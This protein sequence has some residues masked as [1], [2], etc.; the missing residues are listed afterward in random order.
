MNEANRVDD[1]RVVYDAPTGRWT[2]AIG[3][4]NGNTRTHT[5]TERSHWRIAWL[6]RALSMK[7]KETGWATYPTVYG[8][9]AWQL[10]PI[11][12]EYR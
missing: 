12:I 10:R 5:L 2:C 3:R 9:H 4:K 7:G 8:W 1:V 6:V 11:R